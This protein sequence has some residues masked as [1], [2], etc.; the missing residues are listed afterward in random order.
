MPKVWLSVAAP[1]E[2]QVVLQCTRALPAAQGDIS[3][4]PTSQSEERGRRAPKTHQ[5]IRR[6]WEAQSQSF[7]G[8][9]H[10]D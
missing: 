10:S 4:K 8:L 6:G 1:Q 9:L 7:L 2:Y 5:D 3:S